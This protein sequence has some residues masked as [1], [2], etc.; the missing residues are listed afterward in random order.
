MSEKS[1]KVNMVLNTLKAFM[2]VVFPLIT[3]PYVAKI[4]QVDNL[5]KYN[6][7]NSIIN[8]FILLAGLGISSYAIREGAGFRN[9][10]EKFKSFANEIFSIN[11]LSTIL[12]YFLLIVCIILVKKFHT[13]TAILIILSLQIIFRTIGVEWIY[14][15][16]EDYAYITIRSIVFQLISL[17]LLFVFVKKQSDYIIY[18]AISAFSNGGASILN[19]FH[20]K[21]YCRVKFTM[22]INWRIHLKP[23]LIIFSI[24]AASTIYVSSDSTLLGFLCGDYTVGIYSISSKI[25]SIV[26]IMLAS[27]LIVSVPRLSLYLGQ[28]N[29]EKFI[30][31]AQEIIE[32]LITLML[33]AVVGLF[34]LSHEVILFFTNTLYLEAQQSLQFL[35]IALIFCLFAW[36]W[37][38]CI[39][40]P[41]KQEKVI[42]KATIISAFV[43]LLLNIVFIPIWK[44]NAAAFAVIVAEAIAMII[45]MLE[46]RKKFRIPGINESIIKSGIG[47]IAVIGVLY[48]LQLFKFT[49][50]VY[51][52]LSTIVSCII[53]FSVEYLLKNN[54]VF[55][56][57][58]SAKN[59]ILKQYKNTLQ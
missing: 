37:S 42:F 54:A 17:V 21:K 1:L 13:Y 41:L 40:L 52:I 22:K 27:L 30:K 45:C 23:I 51:L 20:V 53:Y 14:S 59:K 55:S 12:A 7:S 56:I 38:Q 2:S 24:T 18:A 8:Y 31:T 44:Q 35:C 34:I 39:L 26:K 5:G 48:T 4:L 16:F 46:A 28:E 47:C 50:I 36:F 10:R 57:V 11:L 19:Y 15:I 29:H 49:S 3:F 6:F 33:P 32:L 25:Y 43:N 9:E 58:I